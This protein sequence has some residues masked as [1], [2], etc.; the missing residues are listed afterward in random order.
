MERSEAMKSAGPALV[1][2]L[3]RKV[4]SASVARPR[5]RLMAAPRG[6]EKPV[7]DEP[8]ARAFQWALPQA[9]GRSG[10]MVGMVAAT[11]G[12]GHRNAKPYQLRDALQARNIP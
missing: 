8:A 10:V 1:A 2:V 7:K 5:L 12:G 4:V 9:C 6:A 3:S 11:R